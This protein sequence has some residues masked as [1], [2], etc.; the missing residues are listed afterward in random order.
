VWSFVVLLLSCVVW[1]CSRCVF[2]CVAGF[3][4]C[5]SLLAVPNGSP[6]LFFQSQSAGAGLDLLGEMG[7]G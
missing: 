7:S 5:V 6:L 2:V 3:S 4:S 1:C